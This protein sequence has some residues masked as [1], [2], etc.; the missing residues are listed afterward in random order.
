MSI[1]TQKMETNGNDGRILV[2][3]EALGTAPAMETAQ[4]EITNIAL[5]LPVVGDIYAKVSFSVHDHKINRATYRS[6]EKRVAEHFGL[7]KLAGH[8]PFLTTLIG[9]PVTLSIS[10]AYR[11]NGISSLHIADFAIQEDRFEPVKEAPVNEWL[12]VGQVA[13][14]FGCRTEAVYKAINEGRLKAAKLGKAF[15]ISKAALNDL[16]K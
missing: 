16:A 15:R 5:I 6:T 3:G 10:G 4:A 2:G 13:E 1:L 14:V 11:A 12:S 9:R 8:F 7:E